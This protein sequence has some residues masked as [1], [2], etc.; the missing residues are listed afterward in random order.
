MKAALLTMKLLHDETNQWV[1]IR[2]ERIDQLREQLWSEIEEHCRAS[3]LI[4]KNM[5]DQIN[6][7]LWRIRAGRY[8]GLE[9][10]LVYTADEVVL[11]QKL[12]VAEQHSCAIQLKGFSQLKGKG[13]ACVVVY[14]HEGK[15]NMSI[16]VP[17]LR[18]GVLM[19]GES[20]IDFDG[21]R[22]APAAR[23]P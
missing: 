16:M 18:C 22:Y 7:Q 3:T 17:F 2:E 20:N 1:C 6:K 23:Q 11:M 19:S 9:D 15:G 8:Q 4:A 14:N 21:M 12:A 5:A 10:Q 13:K